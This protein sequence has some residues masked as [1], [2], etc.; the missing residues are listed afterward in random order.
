MKKRGENLMNNWIVDIKNWAKIKEAR[1]CSNSSLNLTTQIF[2]SS[3]L[4]MNSQEWPAMLVGWQPRWR[5]EIQSF[6]KS[7]NMAVE[8]LGFLCILDQSA[9]HLLATMLSS[10]CTWN[11]KYQMKGYFIQVLFHAPE[12]SNTKYEGLL[13]TGFISSCVVHNF[14]QLYFG[15]TFSTELKVFYVLQLQYSKTSF[16]PLS[17][18][19]ASL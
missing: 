4:A 9:C 15:I 17:N 19:F 11:I 12:T 5:S 14:C 3:P 2:K 6:L 10:T 18:K 16:Y 13:Y 8:N 1:N 7:S